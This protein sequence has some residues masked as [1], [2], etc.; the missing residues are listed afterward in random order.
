LAAFYRGL[1]FL[2]TQG[3]IQVSAGQIRVEDAP[4]LALIT[5]M[6]DCKD[7]GQKVANLSCINK[8][9]KQFMPAGATA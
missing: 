5:T 4:K 1:S 3:L 9:T 2:D 7:P 8:K 6:K